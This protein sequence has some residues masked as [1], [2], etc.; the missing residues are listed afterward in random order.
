MSEA[1]FAIGDSPGPPSPPALWPGRIGSGL[2]RPV[3]LGPECE[4]EPGHPGHRARCVPAE[5]ARV[6]LA[7]AGQ[8]HQ[9]DG[10]KRQGYRADHRYYCNGDPES[11]HL[12]SFLSGLNRLRK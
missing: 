1:Y 3:A 8:A 5:A 6:L 2:R 9:D 4:H 12:S 7:H 11:L 10:D